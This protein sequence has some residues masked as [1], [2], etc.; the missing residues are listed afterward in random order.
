MTEDTAWQLRIEGYD[1]PSEA[2][3]EAA[4]VVGNGFVGVRGGLEEGPAE[5][6]PRTFVAGLFDRIHAGPEPPPSL[7]AAPQL[8]TAPDWLAFDLHV[9][10]ERVHIEEG[11][12]VEQMREL[13]LRD[14][15]LCRRLRL[16]SAS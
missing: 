2:G 1:A 15:L 6:I 9:D 14:G 10:G 4:L 3:V 11:A 5:S 8:V 16:R 13:N 12:C 7:A